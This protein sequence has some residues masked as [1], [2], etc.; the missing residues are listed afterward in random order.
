LAQTKPKSFG[1]KTFV[2]RLPS[3]EGSLFS[4]NSNLAR[5]KDYK[6]SIKIFFGEGIKGF[7]DLIVQL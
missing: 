2:Q 3:I 5:L 1:R 7:D 6:I 4:S